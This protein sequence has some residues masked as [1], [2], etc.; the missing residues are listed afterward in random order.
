MNLR[1]RSFLTTQDY[2]REEIEGL[3]QLAADLKRQKAHGKPLAGRSLALLFFNSSL[4]TRCSFELGMHQL[5]GHAVALQPGKDAW[6][7]EVRE[8]VIMDGEAEEHLKEATTVL[9]RFFDAIAVRCFP[10]FQNWAEEKKDPVLTSIA[11]WSTKPV[12]NMETIVHP[13]QELALGLTLQ[14]HLKA[15]A[16]KKFLL[17]WTYHPKPLNTAVANSAMLL[18]TKLGMDFTLLR[19]KGYDLDEGY[20][21]AATENARTYGGSFRVTDD[22]DA[23]YRGADFVYA[24]SWGNLAYYGRWE[25]EKPIREQLKHFIVDARKMALTNGAKFSHC[26]PLRRNVKA[27][28]EVVDAPYSVIYDEAENRLHTTKAMLASILG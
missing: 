19:P 2:T 6:A 21:R 14:E 20:L 22:I 23:A 17:T 16:K 11:K 24:K 4:R 25:E 7:M 10:K 26:L 15:P 27:T 8:G 18:A 3:L 1:G 5:G 13:C 12:I 28:D 9:S